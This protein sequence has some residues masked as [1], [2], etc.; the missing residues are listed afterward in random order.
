MKENKLILKGR[1]VF[2]IALITIGLTFLTVYLS[3]VNF[4]R[5]LSANLFI[6][7]GIIATFFFVFLVYGLYRGTRLLGN[8]PK[9]QGYEPGTILHGTTLPEFGMEVGEGIGGIILSILLW[10]AMTIAMIGLL[11]LFEAVVWVS[12]FLIFASLYWIFLRALRMVFYKGRK[13]KGDL[14]A[15]VVNALTYTL[16]YTGWLFAIALIV[17]L[18]R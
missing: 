15:A 2:I 6:S 3:G 5:S 12:V 7:L 11:L 8:F 10:I 18:L 16:L 17:Q 9:F 4:N 14:P 1:T 13:T